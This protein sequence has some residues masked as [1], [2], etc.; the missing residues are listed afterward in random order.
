MTLSGKIPFNSRLISVE[1]ETEGEKIKSYFQKNFILEKM[2]KDIFR[3]K[4]MK[5]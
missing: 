3:L 2:L 4:E 1:I 5:V